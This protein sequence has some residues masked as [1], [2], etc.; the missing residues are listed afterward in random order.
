[1][2]RSPPDE[3]RNIDGQVPSALDEVL[4]GGNILVVHME[5]VLPLIEKAAAQSAP[6]PVAN[7]V[8]NSGGSDTGHDDPPIMKMLVLEGQ[9]TGKDEDRFTG[10][11]QTRGL[12]Q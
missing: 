3:A 1:M 5:N 7:V 8:A 12:P 11:G 10:Q 2:V 4:A 6:E 9:K